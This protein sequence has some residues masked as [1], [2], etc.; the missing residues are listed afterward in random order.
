M[1]CLGYWYTPPRVKMIPPIPRKAMLHFLESPDCL[2]TDKRNRAALPKRRETL[3]LGDLHLRAGWGL[4]FKEKV[5]S[6][7][8]V[9]VQLLSIVFAIAV[10]VF[11]TIFHEKTIGS[12]VPGVFILLIGQSVAALLQRWAESNLDEEAKT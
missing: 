12:L 3:K 4:N 5:W 6:L 8:I 7:P 1:G 10:T 11:W 9:T 2:G